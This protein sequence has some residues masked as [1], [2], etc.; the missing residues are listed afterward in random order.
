MDFSYVWALFLL[1]LS[2]TAHGLEQTVVLPF[3]GPLDG[4][5]TYG[6]KLTAA[7]EYGASRP[8]D[9]NFREVPGNSEAH[10]EYKNM[11]PR[12][13]LSSNPL[14]PSDGP[15]LN[16]PVAYSTLSIYVN[17]PGLSQ[18]LN[19][20]TC[21]LASILSG[22]I[23]SWAA[24]D[25]ADFNN[26]L[27]LVK[28]NPRIVIVK[29]KQA[30][31]PETEL[32][33]AFL[34]DVTTKD[35]RCPDKWVGKGLPDPEGDDPNVR[36][37]EDTTQGLLANFFS[38]TYAFTAKG[39][40]LG[41][42]EVA[43]K[44]TLD[45][46]FITAEPSKTGNVQ[47]S[48]PLS[49]IDA[50]AQQLPD[51]FFDGDFTGARQKTWDMPFEGVFPITQVH[52]LHLP[53]N[54]SSLPPPAWEQGQASLL[55]A[56]A[57]LAVSVDGWTLV[58]NTG[59]I[60][61]ANNDISAR[62]M[63][64]LG[65]MDL[66]GE[67]EYDM[68]LNGRYTGLQS[69]SISG[70]R[71]T[72]ELLQI[73]RLQLREQQLEEGVKHATSQILRGSGSSALTAV[74]WRMM[75]NFR[76]SSSSPVW[77]SYRAIGSSGGQAEFIGANNGYE[78]W[79]DFGA[80]DVPLSNDQ[81]TILD[82]QGKETIQLPVGLSPINFFVSIPAG[83]L[84]EGKAKLT[85]CTIVK[86]FTGKI[87]SWSDPA[88]TEDVGSSLP[89]EEVTFYFR[90]GSGTT[91]VIS[92]YMATACQEEWT[93][94]QGKTVPEWENL[95]NAIETT[96]TLD[97]ANKMEK[98]PY[99]IGYMDAGVGQSFTALVE[100]SLRNRAGKFLTSQESDVSAAALE[101]FKG[102]SWP[103]KPTDDFSGVSLLNQPGEKTWPIAT[104]PMVFVRTDAIGMG[105][106]G[107]LLVAFLDFMMLESTQEDIK[108]ENFEPL[109]KDVLTY[110]KSKA[111]P[112]IN[113]DPRNEKWF[114]EA[115][116]TPFRGA[117]DNVISNPSVNGDYTTLSLSR[118]KEE[119]GSIEAR[120][121][122][123]TKVNITELIANSDRGSTGESERAELN[124]RIEELE[125][126]AI[127]GMIFGIA[128]ASIAM[129]SIFR[130]MA[131]GVVSQNLTSSS[132]GG[133]RRSKS[134]DCEVAKR[135]SNDH[136]R[137]SLMV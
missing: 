100:V 55:Q 135:L 14:G 16:I 87:T 129:Y 84:P 92:Q 85:P 105:A 13:A 22:T 66:N 103:S 19:L 75:A 67:A 90:S 108:S 9:I 51:D 21:L 40:E 69:P 96:S 49:T 34:R 25:I 118:L 37:V 23:T 116:R 131:K 104:M 10:D 115:D 88:V 36:E 39:F 111:L 4:S 91:S 8:V 99:S 43:L 76:A 136:E 114:Y 28:D 32:L 11:G 81:W 73:T 54:V 80:S 58:N 45:G 59:L 95:E 121:L 125:A 57:K 126:L 52:Y 83:D 119:V 53:K 71:G 102:S 65:R 120:M 109:P 94:T 44:T 70:N 74:M 35:D 124:E 29:Q 133:L 46:T 117:D 61:L 17:I 47:A 78:P 101:L 42:S 24:P 72:Y 127:A 134:T 48:D 2:S 26:A 132:S 110:V 60:S 38:I 106:T 5:N 15:H 27:P 30:S 93:F 82:N 113:T 79:S 50:I 86:I 122:D 7:V 3:S 63:T 68:E 77:L 18:T 56:I 41:L 123:T 62:S 137:S 31:K 1:G 33:N 12:G 112:L 6:G 128:G 20:T 130:S 64:A 98:N 89:D 107:H 97:L